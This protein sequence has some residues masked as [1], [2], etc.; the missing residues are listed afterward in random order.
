MRSGVSKN[1]Q[2]IFQTAGTEPP[3]TSLP[4]C[5]ATP[6]MFYATRQRFCRHEICGSRAISGKGKELRILN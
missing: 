2:K 5:G 3:T 4:N 1:L 6:N